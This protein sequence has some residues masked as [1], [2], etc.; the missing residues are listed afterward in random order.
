[1]TDNELEI[2]EV[3]FASALTRDILGEIMRMADEMRAL[4]PSNPEPEDLRWIC[5]VRTL[6]LLAKQALTAGGHQ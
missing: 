2:A 6:A 4:I 3:Q 5:Q 1:V